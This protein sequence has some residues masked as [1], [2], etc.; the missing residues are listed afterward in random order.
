MDNQA[1]QTQTNNSNRLPAL[2]DAAALAL[3]RMD[4][5]NYPRYRNIPLRDRGKFLAGQIQ[6]LA[7]IMRIKDFDQREPILMA[8][9]LDEMMGEDRDMM[10]LTLPEIADAFKSGVFGLY[11]EFYGLTAPNLFGFLNSF[12]ESEKKREAAGIV[13]KS[14]EQ[15]YRE[16]VAAEREARQRQI[17]E[18]MEEAKRNGT[19]VP[20]GKAW[21]EPKKVEDLERES[22]AHR[23][24]VRRQAREIMEKA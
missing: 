14:R 15:A 16:R 2:K 21:F 12:L 22:A 9:A 8:Q 18:E 5:K 3:V 4:E 24:K 17:R 1:I 20:T 7:S 11:G 13:V 23:E 6:Y 10:D 19:F